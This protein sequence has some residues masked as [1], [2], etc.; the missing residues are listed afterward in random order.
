M[1][2]AICQLLRWAFLF[3]YA[4]PARMGYTHIADIESDIESVQRMLD[5][6]KR[7]QILLQEYSYVE[8]LNKCDSAL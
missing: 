1:H 4:A 2:F 6:A 3:I 5:K 8:L 7:W